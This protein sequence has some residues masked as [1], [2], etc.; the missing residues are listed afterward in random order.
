[1]DTQLEAVIES[2]R[3]ALR[4]ALDRQARREAI[5]KPELQRLEESR[6]RL[7]Q[8]LADLALPGKP[9]SHGSPV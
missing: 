1:M 3:A 6:Q 9:K 2:I 4:A 8:L 7:E 5:G